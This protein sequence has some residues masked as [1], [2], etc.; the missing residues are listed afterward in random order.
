MN[1]Q[2]YSLVRPPAVLHQ[3]GPPQSPDPE[4]QLQRDENLDGETRLMLAL[5]YAIVV[6]GL[7]IQWLLDRPGRVWHWCKWRR[8]CAWCRCRLSG[9]PRA[10]FTTHG[11][12]PRCSSLWKL[13]VDAMKSPLPLNQQNN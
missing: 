2:L 8:V 1:P 11:I 10:P 9:N 7:G 5:I 4:A 13:H 6:T 12:C 3:S